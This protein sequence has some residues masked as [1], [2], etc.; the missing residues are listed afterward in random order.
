MGTD[1]LR[2][3]LKL[4]MYPAPGRSAGCVLL[5]STGLRSDI[6][7]PWRAI[8]AGFICLSLGLDS[9]LGAGASARLGPALVKGG[10]ALGAKSSLFLGIELNR[11]K[12]GLEKRVEKFLGG[13]PGDLFSSVISAKA[14]PSRRRRR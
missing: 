1:E 9:E 2:V 11:E 4:F 8:A 5:R 6:L 3:E 14:L 7:E 13:E 12:K 10:R